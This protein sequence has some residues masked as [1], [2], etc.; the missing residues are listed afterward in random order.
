MPAKE[1]PTNTLCPA[2]AQAR[3]MR[4]SKG[5]R[6]G[7]CR[8]AILF[9]SDAAAAP[10][11]IMGIPAAFQGFPPPGLSPGGRGEPRIVAPYVAARVPDLQPALDT[12]RLEIDPLSGAGWGDDRGAVEGGD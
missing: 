9:L 4:K 12:G 2:A 8:E 3:V 1:R 5:L 6:G 11:R 10:R 7:E